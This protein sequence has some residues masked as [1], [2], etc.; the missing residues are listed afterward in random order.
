MTESSRD[1]LL[2]SLQE[3]VSNLKF[4]NGGGIAILL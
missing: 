2:L 1:E 4:L 3:E